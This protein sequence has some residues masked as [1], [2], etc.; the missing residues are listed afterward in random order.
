MQNTRPPRGHERIGISG[1]RSAARRADHQELSGRVLGPFLHR[2]ANREE[3]RPR[4]ELEACADRLPRAPPDARAL[5]DGG[6]DGWGSWSNAPND[7][8]ANRPC[9]SRYTSSDT[10][11]A[12][13][14]RWPAPG[15]RTLTGS[16]CT[17]SIRRMSPSRSI[18]GRP[19]SRQRQSP[20]HSCRCDS[21]GRRGRR[22][23]PAATLH[24]LWGWQSTTSS[25]DAA[26]SREVNARR[27]LGIRE[28]MGS[29][30]RP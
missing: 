11:W 23:V 3:H 9:L 21:S 20:L 29:G 26:A 16:R 30:Q 12:S 22:R 15:C 7:L 6:N 13:A 19:S 28:R 2:R 4:H 5:G 1:P 17:S 10:R 24:R 27:T 18:Q 25:R 14:T 8:E